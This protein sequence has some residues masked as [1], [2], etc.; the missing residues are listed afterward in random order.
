MQLTGEMTGRLKAVCEAYREAHRTPLLVAARLEA[1]AG[2]VSTRW[3]Q[4][5]LSANKKVR[6]QS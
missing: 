4:Q 2:L 6:Q 3:T 1:A 5:N